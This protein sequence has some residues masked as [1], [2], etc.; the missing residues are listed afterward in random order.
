MTN[1]TKIRSLFITTTLLAATIGLI[2]PAAAQTTPSWGDAEEGTLAVTSLLF[3]RGVTDREPVQLDF[4]PIADGERIYAHLKLFNKGEARTVKVTWKMA[5]ENFHH[6]TLE[7]G[8][9]ARYRTWAYLTLDE[10]KQGPWTVEVRDD[11]GTLLAAM[12]FMV[13]SP[14]KGKPNVTLASLVPAADKQ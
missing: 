10:A 13:L 7:V 14:V 5:G 9:S 1:Q 11:E 12:P 2:E 4:A 6:Y 8:R 3:C